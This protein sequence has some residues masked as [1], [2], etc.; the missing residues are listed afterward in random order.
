MNQNKFCVYMLEIKGVDDPKN[1]KYYVK[2]G[3]TT[4]LEERIKNLTS[5]K[6]R[7][8]YEIHHIDYNTTKKPEDIEKEVQGNYRLHKGKCKEIGSDEIYVVSEEEMA[9]FKC[10]PF[11]GVKPLCMRIIGNKLI[12]H[13]ING[14]Y[15]NIFEISLKDFPTHLPI[16]NCTSFN[17]YKQ[18][19]RDANPRTQD[20]TSK[21]CNIIDLSAKNELEDQIKND[22][23]NKNK[24]IEV[25]ARYIFKVNKNEFNVYFQPGVFDEFGKIIEEKGLPQGI[26]DGRNTSGKLYDRVIDDKNTNKGVFDPFN[27]NSVKLTINI[28]NNE[29]QISEMVR[30]LNDSVSLKIRSIENSKGN[31]VELKSEL[32]KY[33][34]NGQSFK[35]FIGWTEN[36]PGIIVDLTLLK[37]SMLLNIDNKFF[38]KDIYN[39]DGTYDRVIQYYGLSSEVIKNLDEQYKSKVYPLSPFI[40]L[41]IDK[42]NIELDFN[43]DKYSDGNK[44]KLLSYVK[45]IKYDSASKKIKIPKEYVKPLTFLSIYL[46]KNID[47]SRDSLPYNKKPIWFPILFGMRHFIKQEEKS[48]DLICPFDEILN[49][50]IPKL[51][52]IIKKYLLRSLKEAG[53]ERNMAITISTYSSINQRIAEYVD[54]HIKSK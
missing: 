25:F 22:F 6:K 32:D 51:A 40:L 15:K 7:E 9:G 33:S 11:N 8:F 29:H 19:M 3:Y 35:S 1:D 30:C 42:F 20:L 48:F 28:S 37:Y 31:Y 18:L 10:I 43:D 5:T 45:S 52:P 27:T 17:N 13:I 16:N 46:K 54:E 24:G 49:I 53:S 21:I 50:H 26:G 14:M 4:N 34:D 12:S 47:V 39:E 2:I 41:I 38:P 36:D 23:Y 44:I